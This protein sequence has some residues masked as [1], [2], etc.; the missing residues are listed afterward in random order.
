MFS[1]MSQN[2]SHWQET[3]H[4]FETTQS[5]YTCEKLHACYTCR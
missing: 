2:Y 4:F 5:T 1:E 3:V